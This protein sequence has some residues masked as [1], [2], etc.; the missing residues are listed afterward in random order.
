MPIYGATVAGNQRSITPGDLPLTLFNAESPLTG[1]SS[2]SFNVA[3]SFHTPTPALK[4]E[5]IFSGNPGTFNIQLQDADQD[6]DADFLTV[7]GGTATAATGP[8]SDGTY[9][10]TFEYSTWMARFGRLNVNTQTQNAVTV[11]AKASVR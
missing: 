8:Q 2:I 11:T 7:P 6:V 1:Q 10:F 4:V 9:R 3:K 5:L